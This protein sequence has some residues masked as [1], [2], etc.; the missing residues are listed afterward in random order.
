MLVLGFAILESVVAAG[1]VSVSV[2]A[3]DEVVPGDTF[4]AS[5]DISEVKDL[6]GAQYDVSFD[7]SVLRLDDVTPGQIGSTE[8]PVP[9]FTEVSAGV[10]RVLQPLM[11]GKVSGFGYLSVLHFHAVGAGLSD[12]SL[13]NGKLSGWEGEIPAT[14]IGDSVNAILTGDGDGGLPLVTSP[15]PEPEITETFNIIDDDGFFT[16]NAIVSSEDS[17]IKLTIS[18]DTRALTKENEPLS[19]ISIVQLAEPPAAPPESYFI[20]SLSYALEPDGTS[21]DPPIELTFAYDPSDVPEGIIEEDLV[22]AWWDKAVYEWIK[23]EDSR[24]DINAHTI[25]AS[26]DHFTAFTILARIPTSPTPIFTISDLVI[27]QSR[28]RP[29]ENITISTMASNIGSA[30]G[31]YDVTLKIDG[32]RE[33]QTVEVAAGD[34]TQVSFTISRDIAGTYS[35]DVNGKTASFIVTDIVTG[36]PAPA[37]AETTPASTETTPASTETTPASASS[38]PDKPINWPVLWG[39]IGTLVMIAAL[40]IFFQVRRRLY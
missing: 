33:T 22:I 18:Q 19:E 9:G 40:A 20:I 14:W 27:S 15:L 6:N 16:E 32:S 37:S 2:N 5:V 12:I 1:E 17:T 23:L 35:V 39:V 25:T 26:V 10:Y 29:G 13:S 7:P 31:S 4:T 38:E 3:P 28:V 8:I 21:F 36:E 30:I 11:F 24:V 34:S